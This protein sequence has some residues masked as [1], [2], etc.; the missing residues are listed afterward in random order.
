MLRSG[1]SWPGAFISRLREC[2]QPQISIAA[3]G[4]DVVIFKIASCVA[5]AASCRGRAAG[6]PR[7]PSPQDRLWPEPNEQLAVKWVRLL[8]ESGSAANITKTLRLTRNLNNVGRKLGLPSQPSDPWRGRWL[9][10][11]MFGEILYHQ[12]RPIESVSIVLCEQGQ[13]FRFGRLEIRQDT[14]FASGF[15]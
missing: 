7:R 8:G 10:V 1:L 3:V 13:K 2:G 6:L 15:Y 14:N 11:P 9:A 12:I 4:G 5:I